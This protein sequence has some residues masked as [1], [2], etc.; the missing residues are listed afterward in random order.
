MLTFPIGQNSSLIVIEPG[1]VK[2][3]K[4]GRPLK[5]GEHLVCFTPDMEKFLTMLGVDGAKKPDYNERIEHIVRISAEQ[6]DKALKA[7]QN[8]PEVMR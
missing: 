7:C 5:V 2:M 4:A 6:L 1:N 3:L 8:L